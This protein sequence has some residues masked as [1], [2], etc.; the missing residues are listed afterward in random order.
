MEGVVEQSK[1]YKL[2][3]LNLELNYKWEAVKK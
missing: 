1:I 3:V 2:F